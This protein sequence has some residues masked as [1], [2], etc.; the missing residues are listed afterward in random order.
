MYV[1]SSTDEELKLQR[2]SFSPSPCRDQSS[3]KNM[4]MWNEM[5]KGSERGQTYRMVPLKGYH[6]LGCNR[7]RNALS[8]T[9]YVL[10]AKIDYES[11]NGTMRDPAI[12][13]CVVGI[14]HNR[15]GGAYNVYPLYGFACPVVDSAEG[16]TH[17]LR[18]NE[19]HD[20]E[21]QY[22]P[23]FH[24]RISLYYWFLKH[25]P[26]IRRDIII[27]D[28][29]R[30]NF[31]YTVLSKR[32]LQWFIDQGY[33]TGW[34]DP[35]LPTIQGA[36]RRGL[37]MRA[38]RQ[39]IFDLGDSRRA[40]NLQIDQ[41]WSFNKKIIDP[42]VPRYTALVK[43]N[44]VP[45]IIHGGEGAT[46]WIESAKRSLPYPKSPNGTLLVP[47][48]PKNPAMG[49]KTIRTSPEIL[50]Q[51]F[52]AADLFPGMEVTLM[53]WGNIIITGR[54]L[55]EGSSDIVS[56]LTAEL[57][58]DGSPKTTKH[59]LTWLPAD[60]GSLLSIVLVEYGNLVTKDI[61]SKKDTFTE[62]VNQNTHTVVQCYAD[63]N[64]GALAEGTKV[65]FE[66]IGYARLDQRGTEATPSSFVVIPSG[67]STIFLKEATIKL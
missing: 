61:L 31:T 42:E 33:A 2:G 53:G 36:V 59:K 55:A 30:V 45:V 62:H 22:Y 20:S 44:I 43:E 13:R 27:K 34:D 56:S 37:T 21:E 58:L 50:L 1:D 11:K 5:K 65:Q 23:R 63:P 24:C 39:F 41:L 32:K 26:G 3:K 64:V 14:S 15:T 60:P 67:S 7:K 35:R 25:I 38:L 10:R 48:H 8:I 40:V 57:H 18:S 6:P 46:V 52:D 66:R 28:F 49:L 54:S 4:D 12:Y 29:S 19:Y 9:Q 51:Q 16:V 17:A 47:L